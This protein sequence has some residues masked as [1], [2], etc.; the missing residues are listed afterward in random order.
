MHAF[1][2]PH[3]TGDAEGGGDGRKDR[4]DQ[5]D[6]RF[7]SFLFHI[8]VVLMLFLNINKILL[9]INLEVLFLTH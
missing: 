6:N 3:A 9:K 2:A 7:P 1:L 5:L 4:D 8:S